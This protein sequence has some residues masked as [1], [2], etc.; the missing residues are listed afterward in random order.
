MPGKGKYSN[1]S[2]TIPSS[3]KGGTNPAKLAFLSKLYSSG[4]SLTQ[5]DVTSRANDN[6]IPSVQQ[7]DLQMF[8]GPVSLDYT[9]APNLSDVTWSKPGDPS[10]P[11]T[12]DVRSPGTAVPVDQLGSTDT[13]AIQTNMN[14]RD[15]D[16]GIKTSDFSPNYVPGGP[17]GGTKSPSIYAKKIADTLSLGKELPKSTVTD[18]SGAEIYTK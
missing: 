1:Y 15:G 13:T 2:D 5:A 12:P 8:G 9:G 16:P 4:P 14:P 10:T 3:D 17:A 7:S 6:L 18:S 11:Y